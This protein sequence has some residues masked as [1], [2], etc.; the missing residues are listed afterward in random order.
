MGEI[1]P[2]EWLY[3][4][5]Y[6]E[7]MWPIQKLRACILRRQ[8]SPARKNRT[9]KKKSTAEDAWKIQS[10]RKNRTRKKSAVEDDPRNRPE[11][12]KKNE[13]SEKLKSTQS[14]QKERN[15]DKPEKRTKLMKTDVQIAKNRDPEVR[16]AKEQARAEKANRWTDPSCANCSEDNSSRKELGG[17]WPR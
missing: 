7:I 16:K 2:S 13:P 4:V 9:R 14:L 15:Q 1:I 17:R 5:T 3:S 6:T 10:T 8:C 11:K 12:N